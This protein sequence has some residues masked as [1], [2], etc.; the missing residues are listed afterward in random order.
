MDSI[1][2]HILLLSIILVFSPYL[3]RFFRLQTAPIEIIIGSI[4]GYFGL[5]GSESEGAKYFDLMAEIG[6]LYLMFL[7]GL[8]INLKSLKKMPKDYLIRA[9]LFLIILIILT[10]IVGY[11]AFK[12]NYIITVALPLI[13]VGILAT[14]SK[15]Y[16]KNMD[17]VSMSFL[18][19]AI[20]EVLSIIAITILEVSI[21]VGFG[22]A[23]IYKSIVLFIFLA[24][25]LIFYYLLKL[26]F[27]WYPELKNI[28]MPN[29]DSSDQD[30]RLSIGTFF[31]MIV[32]M[33]ILHL[34]LA[35]GAF[36]AGLFISTFFHHK[37]Q[38]ENKIS[39]FGFGFLI[40]IFF[41]HVGSSFDYKY[42]IPAIGIAIKIMVAMFAIRLLA[43]LSLAKKLKEEEMMLVTLSVSMPLT[44][45]VATATIGYR[46]GIMEEIEYNALILASILEVIF[47]IVAIKFFAKKLID[48]GH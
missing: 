13:S 20:G 30:F 28:M 31:I 25:V 44:L 11:Y 29:I 46:A 37:K 10:P 47:A 6:F 16:G 41:I 9:V 48:S 43:S 8:E 36:I 26:I 42:F 18:I 21:A 23:L 15:E 39:S 12:F 34:E 22:K 14:I 38:L 27:W 24:S 19:G 4:L 17:W 1:V 5:I 2:S 32:I 35:F 33:K 7:A 3:A 40:P 45:L